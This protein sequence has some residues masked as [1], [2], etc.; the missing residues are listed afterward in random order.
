MPQRRALIDIPASTA[1]PAAARGV[2]RA[3]LPSWG[4][5]G[6]VD[7]AELVV[8]ELVTNAYRHAPGI[9]T[10]VLEVTRRTHGLTVSVADESDVRPVVRALDRDQPSGRGMRVIEAVAVAWGVE[11]VHGGKRVWVDLD[12]ADLPP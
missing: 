3:L 8:S 1:G 12:S 7:P 6:L 11:D 9:P 4:L 5:K 2:V 10:F